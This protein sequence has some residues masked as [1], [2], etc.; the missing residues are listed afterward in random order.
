MN[1]EL[2][3]TSTSTLVIN[4]KGKICFFFLNQSQQNKVY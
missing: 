3:S 1:V 2:S 4:E